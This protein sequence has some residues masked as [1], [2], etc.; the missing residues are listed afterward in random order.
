MREDFVKNNGGEAVKSDA[1][2]S[3]G[4]KIA[5]AAHLKIIKCCKKFSSLHF[6]LKTFS[7]FI[8][9]EKKQYP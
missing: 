9:D 4:S 2:V 1:P 7:Q 6:A 8:W 3:F 5:N